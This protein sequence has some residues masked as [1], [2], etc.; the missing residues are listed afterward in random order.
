LAS[1]R[2]DYSSTKME[3]FITI[4]DFLN[5]CDALAKTEYETTDQEFYL[6]LHNYC[7]RLYSM[8]RLFEGALWQRN[9]T[10]LEENH[11]NKTDEYDK[12]ALEGFSAL[13]TA[14]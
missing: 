14:P 6:S 9:S 7:K 11:E 1:C 8:A 3:K 5:Y 12:Y 13:T 10:L 2:K 4:K